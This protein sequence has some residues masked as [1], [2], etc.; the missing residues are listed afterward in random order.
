MMM[1]MDASCT[2]VEG[3]ATAAQ[4]YQGA[5]APP[6]TER[7]GEPGA[8]SP[9]T[10]NE[11]DYDIAIIGLGPA[12]ATLA[13]LLDPR[14][15]VIAIDR[16]TLAPSTDTTDTGV[17]RKPCG[18]LLA[19]D[20]QKALAAFDLTLPADLLVD[21]QIFSVRVIDFASG[22]TRYYQRCYMNMDRHRFDQWLIGLIPGT[23]HTVLGASVR[24]VQ[25]DDDV[26]Y[27]G[28]GE[29]RGFRIAYTAADG[30]ACEVH[31]TAIVGADGAFS[32]VRR[33]L[34]PDAKPRTYTSIQQWFRDEH[35]SPFYSC[36][37]DPDITDCCSW[38][39]SKDGYF[40]FGGAYPANDAR[41]AFERQKARLAERG[42]RFGEVL[43]T[44]AC[45]VIRPAGPSDVRCGRDSGFLI[46]EAAGF[47]SASS[48]EGISFALDS[49]RTLADV[50][51]EHGPVPSA[52][53]RYE[54]AAAPLRRKVLAKIGKAGVIGSPALRGAIMRTGI[55]AI[56]MAPRWYTGSI[57]EGDSAGMRRPAAPTT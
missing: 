15:R 16:K 18:G 5:L 48:L 57:T 31:A 29:Q 42:F 37:F 56:R 33:L 1:A 2:T 36:I 53:R 45:Q 44:E 41:A 54:R 27:D 28:S 50:L 12:G 46:G 10:C 21:P 34:Y 20:A 43:R 39:I 4:T 25:R 17:F 26:R 22:L 3:A 52:N 47:I 35:P 30:T 6:F 7:A 13:R 38:T 32:Q 49:A 55:G 23:V 40:I 51:N 24:S 8:T 19:P 11:D 14:F 9:A